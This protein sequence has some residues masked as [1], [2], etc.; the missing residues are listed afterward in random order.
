[1]KLAATTSAVPAPPI[2]ESAGAG[3]TLTPEARRSMRASIWEGSLTTVFMNWT[4]GMALVGML[5]YY[6]AT[7]LQ[8]ALAACIPQLM[9]AASL[10]APWVE[11]RMPRH[12]ALTISSG[13]AG[14]LMWLLPAL[15]TLLAIPKHQ[16]APLILAVVAVVAF[17]QG[18]A[19]P[20][21]QAWM[22]NTVP[23][24][25]RGHYF[26]VRNGICG[27]VGVAANLLA[28]R[29]LD[30]MPEPVN[31]QIV[32]FIAVLFAIG[33][34]YLYSLQHEPKLPP[35]RPVSMR[36]IVSVPLA[37]RNFRRML[38]FCVYWQPSVLLASVFVYPYFIQY[39][40]MEF[41]EVAVWTAI[42][43][44]TSM[45]A[46][47]QWGRLADR[48]GNKGV[49][50][51]TCTIA[52][53]LPVVWMLATPGDPRVIYF[54]GVV[55][56]LAWSAINP[57]IFNLSLATAPKDNRLPHLSVL[58]ASI[59]IAGFIGGVVGGKL[60]ELFRHVEFDVLGYHWSAYHWVFLTGI[61]LR[62]QAFWLLRR[63]HEKESWRTLDVLRLVGN[64]RLSG[65]PWR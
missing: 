9:Q 20:I 47:P 31:Y 24:A 51:I 11:S 64:V 32:V 42:A 17:F 60:F 54:S 8:L 57:S 1:M 52:S 62:S 21:W 30:L 39:M 49:L 27:L 38:L 25:H 37:D 16:G 14:R 53:F 18:F 22:G 35:P 7:P 58:S 50:A 36:Q 19:A 28:G 2:R 34:I 10:L 29:L 15:M 61:V 13:I 40:K 33:G 44:V 56:G 23:E 63:V 59:G 6:G 41:T 55:E 5:A 3:R 65:F 12:K 26:G 4:S 43:A 45:I 48:V 46:G